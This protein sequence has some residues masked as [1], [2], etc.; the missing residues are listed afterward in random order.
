MNTLFFL[1]ALL[2][3]WLAY[4]CYYPVYRRPRLATFSFLAGWLT[5]ELALHHILVL[6]AALVCLFIWS[7]SVAGLQWRYRFRDLC[8]VRGSL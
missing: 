3:G 7:G 2:F 4:N 1:S 8:S 6:Q 5:G